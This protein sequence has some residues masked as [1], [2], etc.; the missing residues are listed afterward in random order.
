MGTDISW[1][2]MITKTEM[3]TLWHARKI[4]ILIR[5]HYLNIQF[6]YIAAAQNTSFINIMLERL[7]YIR[8][9]IRQLMVRYADLLYY[10]ML[11]YAMLDIFIQSAK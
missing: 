6:A 1:N 10:S 2:K 7:S 9:N 4:L 8:G 5:F 11:C 3:Y